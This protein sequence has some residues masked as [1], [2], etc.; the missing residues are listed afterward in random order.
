MKKASGIL[1]MALALAVPVFAQRGGE[2]KGGGSR[3]VGG[4]HITVARSRSGEGG[5]ACA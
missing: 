2:P 1:A 3:D 4:G 5:Q